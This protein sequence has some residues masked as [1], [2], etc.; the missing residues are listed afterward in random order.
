[1]GTSAS[2]T[3]KIINSLRERFYGNNEKMW[4]IKI[5]SGC[6]N[7]CTY[8]SD[9]LAYRWIKSIPIEKVLKQFDSGL[10]LGYRFFNLVGRDLGSYGYDMRL[11]LADLL[12]QIDEEY[13]HQN[14]KIYLTNVSANSLI[15]IYPRINRAILLERIFELGS[16]IQSGSERILRLMGK[17]FLLKDW[18]AVIRHI[19]ENYPNIRTRTSIMVGFPNETEKDYQETVHLVRDLLFDRIDVYKYE[20]R[21]GIPSLKLKEPVPEE[22]KQK[23]YDKMRVLAFMNNLR[24]RIRRVRF[25]Y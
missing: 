7:C 6:A 22:I 3:R 1:L 13:P 24:K 10:K 11:T 12:N 2:S 23:R 4:H 9:R 5:E 25:T 14:Y 8:C 19:D 15:D 17:T 20:E 21:P 16:H 18:Q